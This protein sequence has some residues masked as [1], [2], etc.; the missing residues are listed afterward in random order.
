MY[1]S[2]FRPIAVTAAVGFTAFLSCGP[3][4]EITQ[5]ME[6][7]KNAFGVVPTTIPGADK[8]TPALISLGEKLYHDKRLS[9][10]ETV[11]CASCHKIDGKNA[12][13]DN[14]VTSLGVGGKR[15]GRN[16]PTVLNAGFHMAQFWDGRA[17]DLAAQAKG[18]ILNPVEMAMPN[19]AAVVKKLKGTGDYPPLFA[20]AFPGGNDQLTYDNLA[21]AIAA[22]ERTLRTSDRLD[23]FQ[24]GTASALNPEEQKG[25]DLFVSTGCTT[26]HNGPL[27]GGRSYQKMGVVH[28]YPN[29]QDLGRFDV[30]KKESDKFVFKVPSLRNIALTAPY[31]HDGRAASL[32][33]AV[34]QMAHLQLGKELPDDQ[35]KPIVAFLKSLSDQKRM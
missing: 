11:A 25:L 13:V 1:H 7:A 32:D 31:F 34:K 15:G 30:T 26:C 3:S 12:G 14:D 35:V 20:Q 28:A 5:R 2:T 27:L 23:Q 4:K 16:S 22:F 9:S 21:K 33:D 18:P 10:D 19:E 24:N 8:D 29:K 17:S 6:T